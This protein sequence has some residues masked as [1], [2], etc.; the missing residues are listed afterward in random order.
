MNSSCGVSEAFASC[1]TRNVSSYSPDSIPAK[2]KTAF[3]Y[4]AAPLI[5][6]TPLENAICTLVGSDNPLGRLINGVKPEDVCKKK[7]RDENVKGRFLHIEQKKKARIA[8][9]AWT[10]TFLKVF[11]AV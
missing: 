11:P 2:V 8:L 1:G 9:D 4:F 6:S 10:R 3:N 5:C 7:A